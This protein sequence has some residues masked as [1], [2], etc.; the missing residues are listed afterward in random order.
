[1]TDPEQIGIESELTVFAKNMTYLSK[2]YF[3]MSHYILGL[4]FNNSFINIFGIRTSAVNAQ[5][6]SLV[7]LLKINWT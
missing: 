4:N 1:M 7:S 5:P 3:N 6:M 2:L